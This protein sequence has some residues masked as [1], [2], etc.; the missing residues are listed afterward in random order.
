MLQSGKYKNRM[1]T[2][3]FFPHKL[4]ESKEIVNKDIKVKF[5]GNSQGKRLLT[6]MN[7]TPFES[8]RI[9]KQ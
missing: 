9:E 5:S 6:T 4:P 1:L 2:H 7:E 8:G 3:P